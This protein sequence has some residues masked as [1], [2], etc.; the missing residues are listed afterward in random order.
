MTKIETME[1]RA[2]DELLGECATETALLEFA[3]KLRA[4][5]DADPLGALLPSTPGEEKACLIANALNFTS[6][7]RPDLIVDRPTSSGSLAKHVHGYVWAMVLPENMSEERVEE[8]AGAVGCS[9]YR[10]PEDRFERSRYANLNGRLVIE[11]PW[12]IGNAAEAF[13]NKWA[14]REFNKELI[15]DA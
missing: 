12:E 4:A 1:L 14:F 7:V 13:D 5:G 8:L 15:D 2:N 10:I 9:T 3:N 6:E 11:L